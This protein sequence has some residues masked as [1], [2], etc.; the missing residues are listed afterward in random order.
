MLWV[1]LMVL[2]V[3]ELILIQISIQEPCG[4][5]TL[6]RCLASSSNVAKRGF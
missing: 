4:R 3:V 1:A 5:V 2:K 6:D